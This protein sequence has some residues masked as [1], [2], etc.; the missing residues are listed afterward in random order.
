MRKLNLLASGAALASAAALA[1]GCG[2]KPAQEVQPVDPVDTSELISD[3]AMRIHQGEAKFI[4]VVTRSNDPELYDQ[5]KSSLP[6]ITHHNRHGA[7]D[8][9]AP[10]INYLPSRLDSHVDSG[11]DLI[12]NDAACDTLNLDDTTAASIGAV[13]LSDQES[14]APMLLW[15]DPGVNGES[16]SIYLCFF[17]NREPADGTILF[18]D[19][20]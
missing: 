17:E 19:N 13:A 1:V 18:E 16:N 14:D 15:P 3:G 2:E 9:K 7:T 20:N 11:R 10:T 5:L 8:P 6:L 4:P 12:E